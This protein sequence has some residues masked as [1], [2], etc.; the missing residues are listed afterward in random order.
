MY[1]G[2]M[3]GGGRYPKAS[4][5]WVFICIILKAG[6]AFSL[7]VLLR[8][9]VQG[10]CIILQNTGE[11]FGT[12][13][14]G[15]SGRFCVPMETVWA[16]EVKCF[17]TVCVGDDRPHLTR[18]SLEPPGRWACA[19]TGAALPI[20]IGGFSAIWAP[21]PNSDTPGFWKLLNAVGLRYHWKPPGM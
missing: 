5:F 20:G 6:Y 16:G 4:W 17:S 10:K 13:E 18:G 12:R 7:Y 14:R 9:V 8:H 19:P 21:I 11:M 2:K 3:G 15:G 1:C